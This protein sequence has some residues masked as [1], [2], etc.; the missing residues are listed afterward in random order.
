MAD[1]LTER[2]APRVTAKRVGLLTE[3]TNHITMNM[4]ERPTDR[5]TGPHT[6][7]ICLLMANR[8]DRHVETR[9]DQ[10]TLTKVA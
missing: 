8:V 2:T 6:M 3:M 10:L 9:V 1:R 5:E 4:G 7:K